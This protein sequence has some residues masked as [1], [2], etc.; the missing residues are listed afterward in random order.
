M[1]TLCVLLIAGLGLQALDVA[2]S[3]AKTMANE[4][5][6][7]SETIDHYIITTIPAPSC[8]PTG[9]KPCQIST[10]STPDS[11]TRILKTQETVIAWQLD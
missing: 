11:Q 4:Y 3:N 1:K 2:S 10:T 9:S 7:D 6:V 8:S 5:Y